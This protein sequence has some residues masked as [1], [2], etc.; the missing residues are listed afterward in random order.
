MQPQ[1]GVAVQQGLQD[2]HH[3]G[4]GDT[5]RCLYHHRLVELIDWAV[6]VVQPAHDRGR[7]HGPYTLIDRGS[8]IG[9][10]G[11]PGHAGHPGDGLFDED[12]ARAAH[13]TGCAGAGDHLHRRNA[14]SAKV[15]EGVVDADPVESQDLGVDAGQDLFDRV[16]RGAVTIN[17]GVFGCR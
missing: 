13:H 5:G 17:V 16:G 9:K 15:E 3:V 7:Q 12:V 10:A 4:L 11:H 14:V 2:V 8:T 1:R 6:D